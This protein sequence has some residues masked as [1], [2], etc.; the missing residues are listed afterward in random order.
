MNTLTGKNLGFGVVVFPFGPFG[1]YVLCFF[2]LAPLLLF[3]SGF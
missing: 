1:S 3:S 2:F